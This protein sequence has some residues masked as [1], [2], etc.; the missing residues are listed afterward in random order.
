MALFAISAR[1][2][3]ARAFLACCYTHIYLHHF[4]YR[5]RFYAHCTRLPAACLA[6][7]GYAA[8]LLQ[9]LAMPILSQCTVS[10][11]DISFYVAY[12]PAYSDARSKQFFFFFWALCGAPTRRVAAPPRLAAPIPSS[13][14]RFLLAILGLDN[15]IPTRVIAC[16]SLPSSALSVNVY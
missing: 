16:P 13:R 7:V 12:L 5:Y 15:L 10:C 9:A 14:W 1:W 2:P 11:R 8:R 3:L 4:P 6:D